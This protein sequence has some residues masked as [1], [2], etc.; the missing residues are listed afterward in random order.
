MRDLRGLVEGH[1]TQLAAPSVVDGIAVGSVP[2]LMATKLD[3]IQ[4]RRQGRDY[5]DIAA[6]A[7]PA[8]APSKTAFARTTYRLL[9]FAMVDA[10]WL[11]IPCALSPRV[12]E[13]IR[14]SVR[15]GR[16]RWNYGYKQMFVSSPTGRPDAIGHGRSVMH[17]RPLEFEVDCDAP[18]GNDAIGREGQIRPLA[19]VI[20][21]EERPAVVSV[22]GAFGSGKTSFLKMLAAHLRLDLGADVVIFNAWQQSHTRDPLTDI[23]SALASGRSRKWRK[24]ARV[25]SKATRRLLGGATT[26]AVRCATLGLVDLQGLTSI[27]SAETKATSKAWR[28]HQNRIDR[29]K[30]LLAQL[31]TRG[32]ESWS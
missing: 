30:K 22:D 5:I 28:S 29:F 9:G 7:T 14:G 2:D 16:L 32:G 1:A 26:A 11:V 24:L 27:L 19:E 31:V 23:A 15:V 17:L 18:F 3:V 21:A 4:H 8:S 12:R 13:E 10:P 20:A 25:A 6:M